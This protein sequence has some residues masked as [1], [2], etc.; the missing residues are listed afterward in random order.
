MTSE[1]NLNVYEI[2]ID[3]M[4]SVSKGPPT[5]VSASFIWGHLQWSLIIAADWTV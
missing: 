2:L 1:A 5:Q 3:A 4:K